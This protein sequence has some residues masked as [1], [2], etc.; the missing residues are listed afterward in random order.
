MPSLRM[1]II[2]VETINKAKDTQNTVR[3]AGLIA[4]AD[5]QQMSTKSRVKINEETLLNIT[6][7]YQF[8]GAVSIQNHG[9][10]RH[11]SNYRGHLV[12]FEVA[13]VG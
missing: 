9:T 8:F 7:G 6:L 3:L 13:E 12:N 10:S 2:K 11:H 1:F 5:H 4:E